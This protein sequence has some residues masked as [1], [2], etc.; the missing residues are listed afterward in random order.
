MTLTDP[1][2]TAGAPYISPLRCVPS[3]RCAR[4]SHLREL[5]KNSLQSQFRFFLDWQR[6]F[7]MLTNNLS[8][9]PPE[10]HGR[11][12]TTTS[13]L[14]KLAVTNAVSYAR[15]SRTQWKNGQA[16]PYRYCCAPGAH[17]GRP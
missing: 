6:F 11:G 3:S 2:P 17:S 8:V 9:A 7:S 14:G 10:L 4:F 13:S 1:R 15:R 5:L 12:G 16:C